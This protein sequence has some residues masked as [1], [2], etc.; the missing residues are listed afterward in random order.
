M[1]S[2]R[3]GPTLHGHGGIVIF[4]SQSGFL[5]PEQKKEWD[6]W[7]IEHLKIMATVP[8][9]HSA[10]R[11]ETTSDGQPPSL[12]MYTVDSPEIFTDPYYLSIR[13]MGRWQPLIDTRY[14]RRDLYAG[15]KEAPLVPEGHRLLVIDSVHPRSVPGGGAL[16]WLE[17]VGL[18]RST[19]Y[20]GLAVVGPDVTVMEVP[21]VGVYVPVTE[22][23]IG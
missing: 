23:I 10:Q 17:C 18:D 22:R 3:F 13:G 5:D 2:R 12:A 4:I 1:I 19:P 9:I 6:A 7:Y 21:G 14:Y 8:G 15:L 16:A 20:R 11:F